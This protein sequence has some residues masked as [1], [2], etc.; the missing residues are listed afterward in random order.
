M[1]TTEYRVVYGPPTEEEAA[2][3]A[4]YEREMARG[5][6]CGAP[7]EMGCFTCAREAGLDYMAPDKD[8]PQRKV[9]KMGPIVEAHRDPTASYVLSCGHTVI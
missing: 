2:E 1:D 4:Y 7:E 5:E 9:V 3:E 6:L 8:L